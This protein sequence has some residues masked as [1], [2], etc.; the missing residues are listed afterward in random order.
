MG[1]GSQ[2]RRRAYL[3]DRVAAPD[4]DWVQECVLEI[5]Q[6]NQEFGV[7]RVWAELKDRCVFVCVHSSS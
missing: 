1:R 2:A 4:D 7:K 3:G 5:K 6:R